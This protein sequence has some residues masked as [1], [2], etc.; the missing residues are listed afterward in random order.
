MPVQFHDFFDVSEEIAQQKPLENTDVQRIARE[1]ITQTSDADRI[2]YSNFLQFMQNVSDGDK[3]LNDVPVWDPVAGPAN[4][5]HNVESW[6]NEFDKSKE[7]MLDE[8][9]KYNEKFWNRLQDEWKALST[10]DEE[11]PWLTDFTDYY[12]QYK[13]NNI[14][15]CF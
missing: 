15:V 1:I 14:K 13:V 8:T 5:S 9:D 11:H 2:Q 4:Q 7:V 6:L 10:K 3:K 12:E